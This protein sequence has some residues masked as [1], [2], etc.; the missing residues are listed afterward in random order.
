MILPLEILEQIVVS[1]LDSFET[2]K[3]WC[4]LSPC[5]RSQVTRNMGIVIISDASDGHDKDNPRDLQVLD[6]KMLSDGRNTLLL[7]ADSFNSHLLQGF[8]EKYGNLLLVVVTYKQFSDPLL[9]VLNCVAEQIAKINSNY[10][11]NLCMI[12]K[13]PCNFLSKVYFRQF[14]LFPKHIR[15]CELH[16]LGCEESVEH[17]NMDLDLVFEVTNLHNVRH[18]FSLNIQKSNHKLLAPNLESI[19]EL[20][21]NSSIDLVV[22][23]KNTPRLSNIIQFRIPTGL[24]LKSYV[25]PPCDSIKLVQFNP[26]LAYP[27]V[28]GQSVRQHLSITT[29]LKTEKSFLRNLNFPNIRKLTVASLASLVEDVT[30][31]NCQF[32]KLKIYDGS[33]AFGLTDWGSLSACGATLESVE[34]SFDNCRD[35]ATFIQCPYQL[36]GTLKITSMVMN[37]NLLSMKNELKTLVKDPRCRS[38][39]EACSKIIMNITTVWQCALLHFMILPNISKTAALCLKIDL[40]ELGGDIKNYCNN[41]NITRS[42]L[43][44]L[45]E[46]PN[47]GEVFRMVL[48]RSSKITLLDIDSVEPSLMPSSKPAL[49]NAQF[50]SYATFKGSSIDVLQNPISPSAFRRNSLAGSDSDTARRSSIISISSPTSDIYLQSRR[51]SSFASTT[52]PCFTSV[53]QGEE[54]CICEDQILSFTFCKGTQISVLET[55]KYIFDHCLESSADFHQVLKWRIGPN[56]EVGSD[57]SLV[58]PVE[59]AIVR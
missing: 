28:E 21:V 38:M 32:P 15:L 34:I 33:H 4:K 57:S 16:L 40:K 23:F 12:Y 44:E 47:D 7:D 6:Y 18:L 56:E 30:F 25:L 27:V 54:S 26:Q 20:E 52:I 10:R 43:C 55:T 22:A 14:L 51:A 45:S 37:S 41:N 42:E 5:F 58:F 48:P 19:R 46:I 49:N 29:S 2:A 59:D 11:K 50:N 35:L 39:V 9:S 17:D 36:P 53:S 8:L 1:G 13:T 3:A 31:E 24:S